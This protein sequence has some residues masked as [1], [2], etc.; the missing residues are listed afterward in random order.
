MP[1]RASILI[2]THSH[3]ST[4][5]LAVAS[6]LEQKVHDVE[7]LIIGDGVSDEVREVASRLTA[8]DARVQFF[9]HPKGAN[10]GEPYRDTAIHAAKSDAIFYLCDDDILMPDHVSD[11]LAL[12]EN[13]NFVQCKNGSFGI[14]GEVMPYPGDLADPTAVAHLLRDDI[15]YNFVSLT[16]TAH[17]RQFYLDANEPWIATPPGVYPD[18]FQWRKIIRNPGFSGATSTRMT[19]LQFPSSQDGRDD[20]TPERR[21]GEIEGWA[22]VAASPDGQSVIDSL[23]ARGDRIALARQQIA[24]H[25]HWLWLRRPTVRA[26]DAL[27]RFAHRLPIVRRSRRRS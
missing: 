3:A 15:A 5:P 10:H 22:K 18:W 2:P 26:A 24:L 23:V 11:L 25:E 21:L 13:H 16:G 9:D 27:A 19:A 8:A 1:P 6:A 4:L 7:V 14:D 17:S 20:W 12:L